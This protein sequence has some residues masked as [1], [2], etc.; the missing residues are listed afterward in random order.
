MPY[1]IEKVGNRYRVVNAVTGKVHA[2]GTSKKKAQAQIR[3][4][5][6][7]ENGR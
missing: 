6:Q 1:R 3:V 7:A 5:E 4:M 2:K